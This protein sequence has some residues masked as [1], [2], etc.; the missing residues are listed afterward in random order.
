[1]RKLLLLIISLTTIVLLHSCKSKPI[2]Y[3]RLS[4]FAQGTT[5]NIIY[6]NSINKDLA[7]Q[8][9]SILKAFDRSLSNYNDSSVISRVNNNDT[10]VILDDLFLNFFDKSK[11]IYAKTNGAFDFTVA[12]VVNA[13]GFGFSDTA[14]VDSVLVDSLLQ[15]VGS[16]KINIVSGKIQ[17]QNP[18]IKIIGNAIAQGYSV[19]IVAAYFDLLHINNYLVEIGG[20]VKSKGVNN[21]GTV[22]RVGIDMPLDTLKQRKLHSVITL[23]DK[24]IATS[25]NYRKFYVKDQIKYSHTIDP[26]TGF[27]VQH[28]LLSATVIANAGIDADALATAFMVMGAEQAKEFDRK[29]PEILLFLIYDTP[30][31]LATYTS[32]SLKTLIEYVGDR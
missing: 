6:E 29:T 11:E 3:V 23:A 5:Y 31:G 26:S 24:A 2:E 14:K 20:E 28:S 22:W 25:G 15:Y 9:D 21:K 27:P 17:K 4:G 19:D 18:N 12:P 8:V 30:S 32:D 7:E 13:W 10:T 16:D 1:M